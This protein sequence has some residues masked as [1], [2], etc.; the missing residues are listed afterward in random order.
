MNKA[1]SL[2]QSERISV[3][4]ATLTKIENYLDSHNLGN[5]GVEDGNKRKQLVGLL[6]EILTIEKLTGMPVLLENRQDGFDGGFDLVYKGQRI[7][8]KTMERKSYVR[9]EFVNNFYIMQEAYNA[10]IIVFCSFH[11]PASILEICGWIYKKDL[12]TLGI[13]YKSGTKRLRADGTSFVF[14]QDNYEVMNKDLRPIR[15]LQ[16]L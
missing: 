7:D 5:R 1:T 10:E 12:P 14:R 3:Q 8:V 9:G 2:Y 11:A 4:A 16:A 13:F 15:E 6:G